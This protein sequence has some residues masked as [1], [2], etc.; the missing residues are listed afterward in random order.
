MRLIIIAGP[1]ASALSGVALGFLLDFTGL[2][3]LRYLKWVPADAGLPWSWGTLSEKSNSEP[4]K[5]TIF[6]PIFENFSKFYAMVIK[7]IWDLTPARLAR[8]ALGLYLIFGVIPPYAKD[9]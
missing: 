6:T 4:G 2:P 1:V 3:L 5:R 7:T 8:C 9:F